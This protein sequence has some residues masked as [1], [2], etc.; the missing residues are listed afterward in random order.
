MDINNWTVTLQMKSGKIIDDESVFT[1]IIT[2]CLDYL[3]KRALLLEME[4]S[5]GVMVDSDGVNIFFK[6]TDKRVVNSPFPF[7]EIT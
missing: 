3:R 6:I 5:G 4:G 2:D 1:G 7:P